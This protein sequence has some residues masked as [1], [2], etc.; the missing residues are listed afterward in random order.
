MTTDYFTRWVEAIPLRKV[1]ED[2][3]M[4]FLQ[5]HI[6]TRFRVPISLVFDNATYFSSIELT[7]F[8]NE[9]GIKLDYSANYY[10]QGN[11]LAESTNKNLVRIIKKTMIEN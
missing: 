2:A 11:G 3:V 1:N 9:R 6:M 5:D 4:N 8:A 7:A 10:P